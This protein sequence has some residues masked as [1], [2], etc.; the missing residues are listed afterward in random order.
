[1]KAPLAVPSRAPKKKTE[2]TRAYELVECK[3]VYA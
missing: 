2:K 1:M 3:F